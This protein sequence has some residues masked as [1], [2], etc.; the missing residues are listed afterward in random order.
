M[1]S[2]IAIMVQ[3]S[4]LLQLC[5]PE[6]NDEHT[7]SRCFKEEVATGGK[8]TERYEEAKFIKEGEA[9]TEKQDMGIKR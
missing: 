6:R 2:L 7:K 4:I 5:F 8:K 9:E 1:V 3:W